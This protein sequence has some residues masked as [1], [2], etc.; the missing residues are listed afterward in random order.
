MKPGKSSGDMPSLLFFTFV[1]RNV[2]GLGR[3]MV[4]LE[5]SSQPTRLASIQIGPFEWDLLQIC[6]TQV[7]LCSPM[8]PPTVGI[9]L[10]WWIMAKWWESTYYCNAHT[11][12][13]QLISWDFHESWWD[14]KESTEPPDK[15][16]GLDALAIM[17]GVLMRLI[18]REQRA[19]D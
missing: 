7:C 3:E 12:M 13:Y 19:K 4:G 8:T 1:G 14:S 2:V 18:S 16:S 11:T 6:S 5:L 9:Y 15:I 17:V 10:T